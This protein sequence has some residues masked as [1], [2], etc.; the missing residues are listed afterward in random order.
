MLSVPLVVIGP[1]SSGLV[2]ETVVTVPAPEVAW[3]APSAPRYWLPEQPLNSATIFA[4]AAGVMFVVVENMA[5]LFAAGDP[6][7]VTVPFELNVVQS[8][9]ARQP[10]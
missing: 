9:A 7:D 1:P 5:I 10:A 4:A 2:V 8:A 3:H 6:E